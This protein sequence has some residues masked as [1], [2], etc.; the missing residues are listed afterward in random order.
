MTTVQ[1]TQ[2]KTVR[3]EF[4]NVYKARTFATIAAANKFAE[5]LRQKTNVTDVRVF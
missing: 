4:K 1:Y 3:G 2:A 5:T